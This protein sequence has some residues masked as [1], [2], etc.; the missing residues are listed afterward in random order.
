MAAVAGR[1]EY[2]EARHVSQ[3][4]RELRTRNGAIERATERDTEGIGVRVRH[5]GGWG[6]AATSEVSRAGAERAF[7]RALAVAVA[8]P[9][10]PGRP[11]APV[12]PARGHWASPCERDPF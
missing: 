2:A 10:A 4:E 7:E 12:E 11:L 6:F 8:Q 5:E 3:R 9:S 1:C